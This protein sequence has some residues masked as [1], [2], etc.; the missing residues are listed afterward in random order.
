MIAAYDGNR[1]TGVEDASG[2]DD[3]FKN[4]VTEAVEY[5]YDR[6][7]NMEIDA[8]KGITYIAYN[9]LNLPVEVVFSDGRR[10]KYLY[11]AAGTKLRK[12]A[13]ITV[14]DY[15]SGKHYVND[16]LSFFSHG[17]GR[18]PARG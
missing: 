2:N 17:E 4:G 11:D 1:L 9:H 14:T 10:V 7:G 3:G 8:N 15:V 13:N 18:R 5:E 12:E 16:S 6:N